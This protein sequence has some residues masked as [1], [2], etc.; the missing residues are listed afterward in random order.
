VF[1]CVIN[2]SE[3][4]DVAVLKEL[5]EAASG[6]LRDRHSDPDHHRSVFTLIND[7]RPLVDDAH[8][9]I[10]A[11]YRR[12]DLRSHQGVHPRFG[13][14][15]VVPFV[16]LDPT[17]ADEARHLRDELARWLAQSHQVPVFLYGRLDDGS[18]RTLPDVRRT[19][20]TSLAPDYGPSQPPPALGA[21]AV[22]ARAILVAWNLW[23]TDVTIAQAR[24]IART[25]RRP[26][27]RTLAFE[28]AGH[29][30]ISCNIVDTDLARPSQ[31]YDAVDD[32]L[33]AGATIA[34]AEL[35]GLAPTSMLEQE[36][37]A[38]WAQLGLS[39]ESTIEGRLGA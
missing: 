10:D 31:I 3:G 16:A 5:A 9:L 28:V 7:P 6:S 18:A 34:R 30:Q 17:Q 24:D 15:D 25:L 23:L 21:V 2:I 39:R 38:R 1:E 13:L 33:S 12:L 27:L 11:A 32:L 36:D 26:G 37:P 14:V 8:A 20:F 4:R 35:V 19:A 22:G 29:V